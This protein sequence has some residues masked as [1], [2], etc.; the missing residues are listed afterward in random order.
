MYLEYVR[1][2]NCRRAISSLISNLTCYICALYLISCV[3]CIVIINYL[4]VNV[5]DVMEGETHYVFPYPST[6]DLT[7]NVHYKI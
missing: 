3:H 6:F 7:Y 5:R 2:V 1:T 4:Y